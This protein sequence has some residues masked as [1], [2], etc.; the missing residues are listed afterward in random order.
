[1]SRDHEVRMAASSE[2]RFPGIRHRGHLQARQRS[3]R[4]LPFEHPWPPPSIKPVAVVGKRGGIPHILIEVQTHKP[5]KQN[6]VVDLLHR[7][8]FAAHRT[9]ICNN[10]ARKSFSGE[11]AAAPLRYTWHRTTAT[12]NS[13]SRPPSPH[14]AQWMIRPHPLLRRQV[15]E[16]IRLL[17]ID[18]SHDSFLTNHAVELK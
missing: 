4:R 16:H 17:M 11:W 3:R 2:H 7:Q 12:S 10:C 15:T 9:G 8:P 5:T 18:S 1:M 6:A 13:E 14:R